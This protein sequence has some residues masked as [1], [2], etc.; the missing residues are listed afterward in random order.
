MTGSL[1]I[2]LAALRVELII[3]QYLVDD[4]AVVASRGTPSG[5]V[6]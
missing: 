2:A 5:T 4:I 6:S 3:G 1:H